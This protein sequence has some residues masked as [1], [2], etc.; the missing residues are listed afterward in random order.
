MACGNAACDARRSQRAGIDLTSARAGWSAGI[1]MAAAGA[2]LF[3]AKAILA[4]FLYRHGIDAIT[5]MAFRML[6][7]L[8]VFA[9]VAVLETRRARARGDRLS[10]RELALVALLG[11]LGYYLSSFLDFWGLEYIAVSLERLILF[12]TPTLVLLVSAFALG[13]PIAARQWLAMAVSYLGLVLV[14]WENLRLGG[15]EVVLGSALV[16]GAA[17]SYALYLI[18]S[19]ELVRRIGALRLAAYAMCVSTALT[20]LHYALAYPLSSLMQPAPVYGLSLLNALFCTVLPVYLT[21]FAIARIGAPTASQLAV[22]GPVSLLF[23]GWW[24][25]DEPVSALQLAGTAVVLAGV[26]VVTTT[27]AARAVAD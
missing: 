27:P 20:M 22:L 4:K 13:K 11:F 6:F 1:A 9:L 23:L 26:W 3:S 17:A 18:L 7:S 5:L 10:R 24:L 14:F 25:L 12:L 21:M 16:F 19:G 2:I 8:P 15:S